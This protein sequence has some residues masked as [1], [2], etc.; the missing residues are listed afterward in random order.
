M[1]LPK[2]VRSRC[3]LWTNLDL[4]TAR[5]TMWFA[6]S[7]QGVMLGSRKPVVALGLHPRYTPHPYLLAGHARAH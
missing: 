6:R 7:S 4:V 1:E 3:P 5:M 2:V